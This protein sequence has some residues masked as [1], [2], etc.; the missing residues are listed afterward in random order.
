MAPSI[1]QVS[2]SSSCGTCEGG[3]RDALGMDETVALSSAREQGF[4]DT[5]VVM[6]W[7]MY[8]PYHLEHKKGAQEKLL[9]APSF[10]L[11]NSLGTGRCISSLD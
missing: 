3:T 7:K 1:T 5:A 9:Q 2:A 11:V 10:Y 8:K 6:I 4:S